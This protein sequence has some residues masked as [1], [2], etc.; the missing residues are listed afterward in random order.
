[1]NGYTLISCIGTGKEKE[2]EYEL[3]AYQFSEGV[4]EASFFLGALLKSG[5]YTPITE[6]ILVGT[7]TSHWHL[8]LDDL[9][10]INKAEEYTK[11]RLK[12]A[13]ETRS[14]QGI[15]EETLDKLGEVLSAEY[16][17]TFSIIAHTSD[18]DNSTVPE[19]FPF[20]NELISKIEPDTNIL[21]DIT[22]AFRSIPLLI[23]Q[24]LQFGFA[25]QSRRKVEL[26]Y[27]D[28]KKGRPSVARDLS[29]YWRL[30]ALTEAKNLFANRLDGKLL[31]ELL[32]KEWPKG[33]EIIS[34]F[35]TIVE[36]NFS[37]EIPKWIRKAKQ[38]PYKEDIPLPVQELREIIMEIIT[39]LDKPYTSEALLAYARFLETKALYVQSIITLQAALETRAVEAYGTS[40]EIGYYDPFQKKYREIYL[41]ELRKLGV[42]SQMFDIRDMRSK[43]AHGGTRDNDRKG[44]GTPPKPNLTAIRKILDRSRESVDVFFNNV[45]PKPGTELY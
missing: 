11:L 5:K 3:T 24:A 28:F 36:C 32:E 44:R 45:K 26:V 34:D 23:Y 33:S 39:V 27:G 31:A 8:V 40:D 9:I 16:G 29:E 42:Y 1:M 25:G 20:Y 30:A 22:H 21:L 4:F 19:I 17:I 12:I 6:I 43:I 10:R 14:P 2:G 13:V 15:S 41:D 37:H 7:L 38:L 18:I 35:S